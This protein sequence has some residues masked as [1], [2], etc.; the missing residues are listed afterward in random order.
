MND[1][2]KE[3]YK[4]H[5][6]WLKDYNTGLVTSYN[7]GKEE[8]KIEGEKNKAIELAKKMKEKEVDINFI[9]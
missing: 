7:K 5:M 3:S 2:L 1:E 9:S 8:G 4:A 6:K